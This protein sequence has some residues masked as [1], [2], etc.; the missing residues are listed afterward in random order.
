MKMKCLCGETLGGARQKPFRVGCGQALS[1][2][3]QLE[4]SHPLVISV[5]SSDR[6]PPCG[7]YF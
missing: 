3:L 1:K 7:D 2:R 5:P 6:H 4:T